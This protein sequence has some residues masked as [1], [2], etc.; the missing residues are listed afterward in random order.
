LNGIT[1]CVDVEGDF[2]LRNSSRGWRDSGQLELAQQVVVL[3]HGA[4]ALKDLKT[5]TKH[6]EMDFVL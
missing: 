1:V 3:R 4:L 2:N 5:K 6:F